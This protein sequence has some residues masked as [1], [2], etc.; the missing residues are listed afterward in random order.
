M[1]S[2]WKNIVEQRNVAKSYRKYKCISEK[3][4]AIP[5]G[6]TDLFMMK[7]QLCLWKGKMVVHQIA[8]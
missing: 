7:L 6:T 3:T 2:S 4:A 1:R 8:K 5:V